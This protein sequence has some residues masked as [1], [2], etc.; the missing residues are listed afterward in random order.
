MA[1]KMDHDEVAKKVRIAW[2]GATEAQQAAA[3]K[4]ATAFIDKEFDY[5]GEP[6]TKLQSLSWPRMNAFF[7]DGKP[8]LGV[9]DVIKKATAELAGYMLAEIP[10]NVE[11]MAVLFAI[12]DPV[13]KKERPN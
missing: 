7:D 13:L 4:D 11:T 8:I 6:R 5:R 12:L 9:P 10:M 2:D 1:A 3:L